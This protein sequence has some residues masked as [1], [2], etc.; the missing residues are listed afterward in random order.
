MGSNRADDAAGDPGSGISGG[1]GGKIVP[2][3]V[4]DDR[5]ADDLGDAEPVGEHGHE[6]MAAAGK[7]GRQVA[8]M[9]RVRAAARVEVPFGVGKVIAA[10]RIPL[11][12][13]QG[14]NTG[15]TRTGAAGQ[16]A[17]ISDDQRIRAV[18]IKGDD[19]AR[20]A[21]AAD[22]RRGGRASKMKT[23]RK[24]PRFQVMRDENGG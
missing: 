24:S 4:D 22:L 18:W 15:R 13:V 6:R 5:A 20:A 8:R 19:A 17:D 3:A 2:P 14:K 1:L 21:G 7:Q 12:D 10:A 11:M 23:Q 16:A 9:K